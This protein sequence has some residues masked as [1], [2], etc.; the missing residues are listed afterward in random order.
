MEKENATQV[1]ASIWKHLRSPAFSM[2]NEK[3]AH[4]MLKKI[5]PLTLSVVGVSNFCPKR[6]H[7]F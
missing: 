3:N 4:S 2:L 5:F 7:H 6:V 1:I